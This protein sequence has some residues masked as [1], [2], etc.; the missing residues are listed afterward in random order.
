MP[1]ETK[2]S[3]FPLARNC[4]T[5]TIEAAD[6]AKLDLSVANYLGTLTD[7]QRLLHYDV[8]VKPDGTYFAI[9]LTAG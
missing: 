8:W 5:R 2:G 7:T 6:A 3:A 4:V 1:A 9:L